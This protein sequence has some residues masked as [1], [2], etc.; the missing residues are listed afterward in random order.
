ML[1]LGVVDRGFESRR[2][3]TKDYKMVNAAFPLGKD[4]LAWN[5]NNMS[6]WRDLS[7][8]TV[9]S[10]SQLYKDP[11]KHIGLVQSGLNHHLIEI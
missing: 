10:E 1:T 2:G 4:W 3:Q 5:Q 6:E 9:V 11:I 7:T 8:H